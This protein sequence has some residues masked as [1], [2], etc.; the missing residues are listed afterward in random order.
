MIK[1]QLG[2]VTPGATFTAKRWTAEAESWPD[3]LGSKVR[4]L[5]VEAD[6]RRE[7]L[8]AFKQ[9]VRDLGYRGPFTHY[10]DPWRHF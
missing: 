2:P 5:C 7:A 9:L 6:S 4:D 10:V 8:K 3:Y 1:I